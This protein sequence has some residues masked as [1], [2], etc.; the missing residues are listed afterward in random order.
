MEGLRPAPLSRRPELVIVVVVERQLVLELGSPSNAAGRAL[1][2]ERRRRRVGSCASAQVACPPC[3]RTALVAL[4]EQLL[5]VGLE[6]GHVEQHVLALVG[7]DDRHG[8]VA[9][10]RAA[11]ARAGAAPRT[12][13]VRSARDDLLDLLLGEAARH[14]HRRRRLGAGLGIARLHRHDAFGADRE[15][16]PRSSPRRAGPAR[17]RRTRTRRAACCPRP[18]APRP[19]RCAPRSLSW[20]SVTVVNTRV[21]SIGTGL[22][23]S[24]IGS[25]RPPAMPMPQR[26]RRDVEQVAAGL[27]ARR[28]RP[29]GSPRRS[30]RP[31]RG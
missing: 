31:R 4:L 23:R 6:R 1:D 28:A 15:G 17:S 8:R 10:A 26:E 22:L 13:A 12:S 20:L 5:H 29:R 24:M 27:G 2:R 19:G 11:R 21:W 14:R 3:R 30:R 7:R 25:E 16:R 18:G 9:V